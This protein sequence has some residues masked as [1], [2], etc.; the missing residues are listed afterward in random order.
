V[1]DQTGVDTV[2]MEL[3]LANHPGWFPDHIHPNADGA[4]R[5]AEVICGRLARDIETPSGEKLTTENRK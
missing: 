5:I 2:D 3:S 1:A 4:R